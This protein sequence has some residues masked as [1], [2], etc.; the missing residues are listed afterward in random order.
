MNLI[1]LAHHHLNYVA[2]TQRITRHCIIINQP[3]FYVNIFVKLILLY[4]DTSIK[5]YYNGQV[6][7]QSS[8]QNNAHLLEIYLDDDWRPV[9]VNSSDV[10]DVFADSACRQM[11]YTAVDSSR[12]YVSKYTYCAFFCLIVYCII[13]ILAHI[14]YHGKLISCQFAVQQMLGGYR[15]LA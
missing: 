7:L 13:I 11:G 2:L 5:N 12:P 3:T 15:I 8:M 6:R 9:C 10:N 1:K 14:K 4:S